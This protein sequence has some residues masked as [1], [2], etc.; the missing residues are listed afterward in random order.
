MKK[1]FKKILSDNI[2]KKDQTS[3]LIRFTPVQFSEVKKIVNELVNKNVVLLDIT[4]ISRP[5][6]VRLIDFVSGALIVTDGKYKKVAPKT[7]LLS[8]SL[9]LLNA[10]DDELK[11]DNNG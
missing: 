9:S 11:I 7:Y 2:Q 8:P 10:F 4:K 6:A 3:K 5:E 1:F